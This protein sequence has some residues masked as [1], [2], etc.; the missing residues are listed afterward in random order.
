M[1]CGGSTAA[2]YE[3]ADPAP[4][5]NPPKEPEV[6]KEPE[7]VEQLITQTAAEQSNEAKPIKPEPEPIKQPD[8][9]PIKQPE[10]EP[11]KDTPAVA[12]SE[13]EQEADADA[14]ATKVQATY[15]GAEYRKRRANEEEAAATI[16]GTFGLHRVSIAAAPS[17]AL[18]SVLPSEERL[19]AAAASV[20]AAYRKGN[21]SPTVPDY[22]DTSPEMAASSEQAASHTGSC[23]AG[24][25][26]AS[27]VPVAEDDAKDAAAARV[28][29]AFHL[30]VPVVQEEPLVRI[31]LVVEDNAY[32]KVILEVD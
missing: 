17:A 3:A 12:M 14:A 23:Q 25:P 26:A 24:A 13:S 27:M 29:A 8:P 31:N 15:R 21:V 32:L 20:Q 11:I 9:E 7:P 4:Q 19:N 10:S 28:Q 6:S 5:K 22:A 18:T 1:G 16:Q 2:K 30:I